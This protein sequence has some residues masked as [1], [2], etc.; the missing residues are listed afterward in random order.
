MTTLRFDADDSRRVEALYLTPDVAEQRREVLRQLAPAAGE[1]VLDIGSGP[2]LLAGELAAAVGP[3]GQ[4][5]GVDLSPDMLAL[6]QARDLPT[7]CAPVEYLAAGAQRLPY[8]DDAFD[9]AVST[10]VME[11]VPDVAAALAEAY[12]VLRPGGRL[13]LLDTDWDSIVWHSRDAGRMRRVLAAW[14]Q[15]LVDPY[16]P[17][18]LTSEL[19]GAGFT[20]AAPRVLPML[21]AGASAVAAGDAGPA[22]YSAG[23]IDIVA[24]FVVHR[25]GLTATDVAAWAADLRSLGPDYFF[26]LNRYLFGATKPS[27][28]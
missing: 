3:T 5:Y 23:L 4:V 8:P 27:I 13:L 24:A 7:G 1:R 19:R 17:R 25:D 20:V 2:G 26:S 12:R 15:H 14:D 6:A 11:Y 16:L 21:N 22:T 18:T 9:L 10:Q 28:S